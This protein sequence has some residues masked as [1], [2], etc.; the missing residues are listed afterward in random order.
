MTITTQMAGESGTQAF[1][2]RPATS[3]HEVALEIATGAAVAGLGFWKRG[4]LGAALAAGGGYLVYCGIRDLRRPYQG[5]V[6]V[7]FTIAKPPQEIFDFVS[8]P[9]N[10]ARFLY[11]IRLE[12]RSA[13]RLRL[14]I[15]EP[16]GLDFE[17]RIE[18]T[19]EKP[20]EFVAWAS[21]EQML[22]HRGVIRLKPAPAERGTEVSV[23]MEY[24]APSGPLSNAFASLI[25]WNPEQVVRESLRRL[26]QLME[27][28]EIPTTEGQPVGA[29]GIKGKSKRVLYREPVSERETEPTR[30]AGD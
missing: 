4:A 16:P 12:N 29:R 2:R 21:A 15:D 11:R 23:A 1:S 25:G 9:G 6:R 28:G 22:E 19:D 17:S 24:K 8:N 7:A 27:A 30:L 3:R 10:W 26:K 5:R 20:G 13:G 18:I 14:S